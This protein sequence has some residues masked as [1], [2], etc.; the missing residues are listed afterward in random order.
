[1]QILIAAIGKCSPR[2][3]EYALVEEYI[4]RIPWKI[5][6]KELEYK[7]NI[8]SAQRKAAE[9]S[10]LLETA[11]GAERLI[12]LDEQGKS[13]SSR[14]F[15]HILGE[16]QRQGIRSCAFLIGG[17]DGLDTS[18]LGPKAHLS[19]SFGRMSWPHMLARALLSE[20][21]YRAHALLSG[22]PYHR[23]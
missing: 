20:Q 12:T 6:I 2:S 10:L 21:L 1:M 18:L 14:E 7:K 17:S 8:S 4:K 3:P 13:L 11:G 15:A 19:L 5:G 9:A 23:D 22:H 16:W